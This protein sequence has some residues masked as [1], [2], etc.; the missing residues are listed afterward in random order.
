VHR[1]VFP[2]GAQITTVITPI[3]EISLNW[4]IAELLYETILIN[5]QIH[6]VVNESLQKVMASA[7]SNKSNII[8]I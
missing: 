2:G 5:H 1:R 6:L 8:I 7:T 4:V 3:P